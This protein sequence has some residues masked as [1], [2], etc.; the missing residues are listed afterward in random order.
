MA[1]GITD[2][3]RKRDELNK[4]LASARNNGNAVYDPIYDAFYDKTT[5]EW[6]ESTCDH[7]DCAF[8]KDRPEKHTT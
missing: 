8:C 1:G 6:L 4:K 2:W 3:W 5:G 7:P